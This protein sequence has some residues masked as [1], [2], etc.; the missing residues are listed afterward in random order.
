M[1]KYIGFATGDRNPILTSIG[2]KTPTFVCSWNPIKYK[3]QHQKYCGMKGNVTG[4]QDVLE[5]GSL[6]LPGHSRSVVAAFCFNT[7]KL[8]L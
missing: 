3:H 7:Y 8:S 2:K 4:L 5:L 1:G 6:K